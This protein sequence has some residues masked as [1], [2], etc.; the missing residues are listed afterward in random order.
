M[1]FWIF[2]VASSLLFGMSYSLI[3]IIIP[4]LVDYGEYLTGVR[5]DGGVSATMDFANKVGMA[6]GTSGMGFVLA[7]L[8]FSANIPQTP[9][10]MMGINAL[11]FIAPG[12]LS[13]LI[14]VLFL[15][16]RLDRTVLHADEK[17]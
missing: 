5:N 16:Y 15:W 6:I 8:G 17:G 11:M 4:D 1:A 9:Q 14:G 13:I 3:Y 12:I 7:A 2:T 10:V